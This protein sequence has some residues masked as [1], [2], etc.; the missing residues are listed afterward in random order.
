VFPLG[1]EIRLDKF[2][3]LI[4]LALANEEAREQLAASRAR[5]LSTADAER[6]RLE[7][8]LHD[9]AQQRLVSLSLSLRHIQGRL[10]SDPAAAAELLTAANG[11]L[12]VALEELGGLARGIHPAALPDRGLG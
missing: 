9:G 2:A 7:R 10:L 12:A 4:S 6:R 8:N 5:L 3:R 1:A 11:E